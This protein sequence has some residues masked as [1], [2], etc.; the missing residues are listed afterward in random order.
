MLVPFR[1]TGNA[2]GEGM[3]RLSDGILSRKVVPTA[4]VVQ[5]RLT[6]DGVTSSHLLR[7]VIQSHEELP[8][9]CA[10]Q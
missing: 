9:G 2:A 3:I 5:R 7:T 10:F 4:K 1:S 8:P 6:R